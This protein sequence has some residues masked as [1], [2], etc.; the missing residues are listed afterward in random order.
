V[1]LNEVTATV[2]EVAVAGIVNELM[3]GATSS[4]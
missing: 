3:I 4:F 2:V 1:A